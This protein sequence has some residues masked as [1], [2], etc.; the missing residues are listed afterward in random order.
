M[1][2][3][4]KGGIFLFVPMA[5]RRINSLIAGRF[6]TWVYR[7]YCGSLG[8]HSTIERGAYMSYPANVY[9]GANFRGAEGLEFSSEFSSSILRIEDGVQINRNV[10]IDYTG[11]VSIDKNTLI[12]EEVVIYSH[13]HGVDPRSAPTGIAKLIG[14]EVWV[15]SRAIILEGCTQIGDGALIAAGAVVTRDVPP[16]AVVGGNPAR[17]IKNRH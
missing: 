6:S 10:K 13:S 7:R 11:N 15:G 3:F 16:G 9:I 4:G 8:L 5:M 1:N 12:S 2:R 17:I 14:R